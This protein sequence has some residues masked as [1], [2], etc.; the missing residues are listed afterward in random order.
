MNSFFSTILPAQGIY[1]ITSIKAGS[2]SNHAC[3]SFDEMVQKVHELDTHGFDTFF[4]CASFKQE[5]YIDGKD[6]RRQR[7]GDNAGWVKSFWLD[8]DCGPDKA[9]DGKGY[10]KIKEALAAL[11]EFVSVVGLQKP[12]VVFSGGGLHVYWLLA[13]T[14]TKEQWIPVAEQLKALTHCP[15]VR[16]IADNSRTADIAS[17]L[18]PIG[19]HNY[20]PERN[21]AVVTQ[22]IAGVAT[23][24]GQF[25]QI[26]SE[27]HQTHC[28]GITR[29]SSVI[30]LS[31]VQ[32]PDPETPENIARLKSALGALNPDCDRDQWRDICFAVH[33]TGWT[34]AEELAR[35]WSRGD[36]I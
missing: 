9:E 36:L 6:K 29:R 22:K 16:L 7:T 18:R 17:V 28:G 27:A 30:Q 11:L 31:T 4:A 8:I 23:D 33:S 34:C 26:I 10:A 3:H 32:S 35:S 15:A 1:F 25:S 13:N 21:G 19:T 20:K 14:I 24:F 2:C 12:T 5:S